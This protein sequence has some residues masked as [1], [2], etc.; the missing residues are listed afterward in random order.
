MNRN[1]IEK[2]VIGGI[3]CD[4]DETFSALG[5]LKPS[6]FQNRKYGEILGSM[7]KCFARGDKIDMINLPTNHENDLLNIMGEV[8]SAIPVQGYT[9]SILDSDARRRALTR[10]NKL[11]GFKWDDNTV[12]VKELSSEI[13][14]ILDELLERVDSKGLQH[15][16]KYTPE[17]VKSLENTAKGN[18]GGIWTGF[19]DIDRYDLILK[20]KCLILLMA[21][22]KVGKTS[23]AWN[24]A[25]RCDNYT[26]FFSHE[27]SAEQLLFRQLCA[28]TGIESNELYKKD[29]ISGFADKLTR[30]AAEM[31]KLKIWIDET[32]RRTIGDIRI[33]CKRYAADHKIGLIIVDYLQLV[34]WPEPIPLRERVGLIGQKLC[35]IAQ[36]FNCPIVAISS[37]RRTQD[38]KSPPGMHDLKESGDLEYHAD[39]VLGL[40]RESLYNKMKNKFEADLFILA[41]RSGKIGRVKLGYDPSITT[42]GDYVEPD[43][44]DG[45]KQYR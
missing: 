14:L 21:R 42:F 28:T 30:H 24:L 31:N 27:M 25:T 35:E 45:V 44:N 33:Q 19:A 3:L 39:V 40:H 36:E 22:P 26:L 20:N 32:R 38:P 15:I 12:S 34:Q 5:K 16:S 4:P 17:L 11:N 18:A 41:N 6:M 43:F 7:Q 10:L 37:M 9:K 23:F 2:G 29:V 1:D 13:E 8:V